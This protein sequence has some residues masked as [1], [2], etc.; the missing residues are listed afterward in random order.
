M[1][2]LNSTIKM[3]TEISALTMEKNKAETLI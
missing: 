3:H 1:K 2:K